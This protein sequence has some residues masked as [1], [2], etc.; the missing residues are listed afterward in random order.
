[1]TTT[2]TMPSL[3]NDTAGKPVT[4]G[5]RAVLMAGA[6]IGR[7]GTVRS[8]QLAN[9]KA[10][11]KKGPFAARIADG[12]EDGPTWSTWVCSKAFLVIRLAAPPIGNTPK[13]A[14]QHYLMVNDAHFEAATGKALLPALHAGADRS[15]QMPKVTKNMPVSI[16]VG[17]SGVSRM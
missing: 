17:E 16:G 15:G 7:V 6:F 4:V 8:V 2:K 14:Q 13:V 3:M 12:P 1:M 11:R 10:G 9:V 5:Q